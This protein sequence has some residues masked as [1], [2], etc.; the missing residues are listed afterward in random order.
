M[1]IQLKNMDPAGRETLRS[2]KIVSVRVLE[3]GHDGSARIDLNGLKTEAQIEADVPDHF[4]AMVEIGES[5]AAGKSVRLRVLSS[6]QQTPEFGELSRTKLLEIVR[7]F[8][9]ENH[10]PLT[11]ETV[12]SALLAR[13][14]GIKLDA[15]LV[16]LLNLA[17][18]KGGDELRMIVIRFLQN[19]VRVNAEFIELFRSWKAVLKKNAAPPGARV[20]AVEAFAAGRETDADPVTRVLEELAR[21]YFGEGSFYRAYLAREDGEEVIVQERREKTGTGERYYFDLTSRRT[22]PVL[23]ILD[24]EPNGYRAGVY[25]DPETY[26]E[27][28]PEIRERKTALAE[29]LRS[30]SGNRTVS[31]GFFSLESDLAFWSAGGP[32]EQP[33]DTGRGGIQD[34]DISV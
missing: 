13:A 32:S 8:L 20:G 30:L 17:F 19:G 10:L 4:L 22:G 23:L 34:L 9:L 7:M 18:R 29:R 11:E 33:G 5:S 1:N 24:R 16:K 26:R 15:S 28:E 25:I 31:V 2:D 12:A 14:A 27:K 6:L 21:R 3:R